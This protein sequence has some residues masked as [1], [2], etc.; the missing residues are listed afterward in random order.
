MTPMFRATTRRNSRFAPFLAL[1][2]AFAAAFYLAA[3]VQAAAG[4]VAHLATT[5]PP[6]VEV[7][8]DFDPADHV[9]EDDGTTDSDLSFVPTIAL[10]SLPTFIR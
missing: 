8:A 6:T 9:A 7:R 2:A 10:P 5:E 3:G 4:T 1:C